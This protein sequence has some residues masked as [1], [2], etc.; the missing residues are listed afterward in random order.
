MLEFTQPRTFDHYH[1]PPLLGSLGLMIKQTLMS[2]VVGI[3]QSKQLNVRLALYKNVFCDHV[4]SVSHCWFNQL[5]IEM[6][7]FS[8]ELCSPGELSAWGKLERRHTSTNMQKEELLSTKHYGLLLWRYTASLRGCGVAS[9]P[10]V[11]LA[12]PIPFAPYPSL[13]PGMGPPLLC[14][15]MCVCL[16]ERDDDCFLFL[17]FVPFHFSLWGNH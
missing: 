8:D 4:E 10:L 15:R 11:C 1:L 12:S 6:W 3:L 14:V 7:H 9:L 5:F 17:F 2:N 16:R 13:W